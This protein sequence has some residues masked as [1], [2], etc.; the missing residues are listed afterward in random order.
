MGEEEKKRFVDN[1]SR[2]LSRVSRE[3]IIGKSLSHFRSADKHFGDRLA[4]AVNAL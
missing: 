1:L 3:E 2:S 4:E